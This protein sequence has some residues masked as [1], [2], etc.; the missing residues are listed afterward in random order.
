MGGEWENYNWTIIKK[1]NKKKKKWY[2]WRVFKVSVKYLWYNV[3]W[4]GA[5]Y[6]TNENTILGIKIHIENI[7]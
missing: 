4:K 2:L 7:D 3:K 1:L 5:G 6:K